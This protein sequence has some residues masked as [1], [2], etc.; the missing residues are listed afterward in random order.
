MV[1]VAEINDCAEI[2]RG[3][4]LLADYGGG[5]MIDF[6]TKENSIGDLALH[7]QS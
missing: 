5:A 7:D 1:V 4:S 6:P 2:K 3:I